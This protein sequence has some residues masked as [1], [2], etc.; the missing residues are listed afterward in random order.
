[1]TVIRHLLNIRMECDDRF[2]A[3]RTAVAQKLRENAVPV[4][5]PPAID[6]RS[7]QATKGGHFG[8]DPIPGTSALHVKIRRRYSSGD[9]P[10]LHD[11]LQTLGNAADQLKHGHSPSVEIDVES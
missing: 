4:P 11:L 3:V 5:P 9:L 6:Y 10:A 8:Q 2:G 7:G 1:M